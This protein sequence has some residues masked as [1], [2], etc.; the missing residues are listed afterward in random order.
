MGWVSAAKNTIVLSR[1]CEP[2]ECSGW[3]A[4]W[5]RTNI[6]IA[7]S[8]CQRI[9]DSRYWLNA[10]ACACVSEWVTMVPALVHQTKDWKRKTAQYA[11]K[12]IYV[13]CNDGRCT[14]WCD[15]VDRKVVYA[16]HLLNESCNLCRV[17]LIASNGSAVSRSFRVRWRNGLIEIECTKSRCFEQLVSARCNRRNNLQ[18]II[19]IVKLNDERNNQNNDV[20]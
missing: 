17:L 16:F 15:K 7:R 3:M 19:Y 9:C 8:N 6:S 14:A 11:L 13:L 4:A 1:C 12:C 20:N 5:G 18:F 2:N 10:S